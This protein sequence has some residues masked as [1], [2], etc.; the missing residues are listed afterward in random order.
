MP[1]YIQ[2]NSFQVISRE[3]KI[4]LKVRR[5]KKNKML[6]ILK[7][8]VSTQMNKKQK[9]LTTFR[10]MFQQHHTNSKVNIKHLFNMSKSEHK[11]KFSRTTNRN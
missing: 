9:N 10:S 11:N 6:T 2:I 7:K 5:T 4:D 8:H 1:N 3:K